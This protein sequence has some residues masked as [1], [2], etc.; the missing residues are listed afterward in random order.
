MPCLSQDLHVFLFLPLH[1]HTLV[2]L[3]FQPLYGIL[4]YWGLDSLPQHSVE[5]DG[6]LIY[7][8]P[9][10]SLSSPTRTK[11]DCIVIAGAP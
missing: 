9:T 11:F 7:S 4:F 5:V 1:S 10:F 2:Y 3:L 8:F 6:F